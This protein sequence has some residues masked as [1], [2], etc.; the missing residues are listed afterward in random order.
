HRGRHA[1]VEHAVGEDGVVPTRIGPGDLDRDEPVADFDVAG[2]LEP[3]GNVGSVE[4]HQVDL[5][6]VGG[7]LV[8]AGLSAGQLGV[9]DPD[10]GDR[11]DDHVVLLVVAANGFALPSA[12]LP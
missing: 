8:V 3:A 2:R 12:R 1:R 4:V 9:G 10:R 5:D 6:A 11:L 7:E